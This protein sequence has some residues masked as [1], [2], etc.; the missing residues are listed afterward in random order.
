MSIYANKRLRRALHNYDP[1]G[2]LQVTAAQ[3]L[4]VTTFLCLINFSFALPHFSSAMKLIA[5]AFLAIS[6]ER[7]FNQRMLSMAIFCLICVSY[8]CILT[9]LEYYRLF[10]VL[11]MGGVTLLLFAISKKIYPSLLP[12][13]PIVQAITYPL[14]VPPL[15]GVTFR[16][17]QT[18]VSYG[19]VVFL[20]IGL[21]GFFPRIYFF[22]I[23]LR[24]LYL[25][26]GEFNENCLRLANHSLKTDHILFK[27]MTAMQDYAY[28]LGGDKH[29]IS[30][31]K[32]A[33][34]FMKMYS[35]FMATINGIEK[36]SASELVELANHCHLL[37]KALSD[38]HCITIVPEINSSNQAV[39][40][41]FSDLNY[42]I[43]TWNRLCL[44]T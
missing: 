43:N 21:M 4:F 2:F 5:L 18:F 39:Q 8:S 27:H 40:E 22:R 30:A 16:V 13:I 34:N 7:N 12:M 14:I 3:A 24:A 28:A 42:I 32:I 6:M 29:G 26:L 44:K 9:T 10:F 19:A 11:S 33:L 1:Y 15:E 17:V 37:Q 35:F 25:T 41:V 38:D 31:Q 36:V 23:F 20:T